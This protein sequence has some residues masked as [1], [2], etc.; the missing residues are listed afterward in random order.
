MTK[1][2]ALQ[3]AL[4]ALQA[5]QNKGFAAKTPSDV[6]NCVDAINAIKETLNTEETV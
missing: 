2:E 5:L 1:D 3:L 4:E 6:L